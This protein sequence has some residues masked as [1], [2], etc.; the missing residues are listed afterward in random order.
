MGMPEGDGCRGPELRSQVSKMQRRKCSKPSLGR[1][2]APKSS[3]SLP[4]EKTEKKNTE[5]GG[6]RNVALILSCWMGEQVGLR[7]KNCALPPPPSVRNL[8]DSVRGGLAVRGSD[9]EQRWK[10]LVFFLLP[11]FRN[12]HGLASGSPV[13]G[14]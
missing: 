2:M 1:M 4:A 3:L 5:F 6:N 9:G 7:L 8:G 14:W 11:C 10:D 13:I 12:S